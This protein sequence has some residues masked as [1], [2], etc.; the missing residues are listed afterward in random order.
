MENMRCRIIKRVPTSSAG[1]A[2]CRAARRACL[3]PMGTSSPLRIVVVS[4]RPLMMSFQMPSVSFPLSHGSPHICATF[5][6]SVR[7]FPLQGGQ[8][9]GSLFTDTEPNRSDFASISVIA[10]ALRPF[11]KNACPEMPTVCHDV[12]RFRDGLNSGNTSATPLPPGG[13]GV[14]HNA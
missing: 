8:R 7:P 1:A 10:A 14:G 5:G 13:P 9:T 2:P 11:Q 6:T 3:L 12:I 4:S